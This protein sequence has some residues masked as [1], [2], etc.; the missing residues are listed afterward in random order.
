MIILRFV[1]KPDTWLWSKLNMTAVFLMVLIPIVAQRSD[2]DHEPLLTLLCFG[3]KVFVA[4][5]CQQHNLF[6]NN[7]Q[8]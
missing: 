3:N 7:S 1:K 2:E 4:Q 8:N 5:A 6:R